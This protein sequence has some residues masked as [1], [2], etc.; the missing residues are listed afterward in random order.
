[1]G[2]AGNPMHLL[3][4]LVELDFDAIEAYEAAIERLDDDAGKKAL[5]AFKADHERHVRELGGALRDMGFDPPEQG[6]FRRMLAKGKVVLGTIAGDR[7][8]LMAMK[9]NEDDTNA[10][11]ERV[12]QRNDLAPEVKAL[13]E[14]NLADERRHRDWIEQRLDVV[15]RG[16]GAERSERGPAAG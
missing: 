2:N 10:A 4:K 11:Y 9:A 14:K 6:D 13:I 15:R 5:A 12:A 3:Y 16:R 8:I 1:M 7:G